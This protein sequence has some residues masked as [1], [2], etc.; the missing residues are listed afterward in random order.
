[1]RARSDRL[2][3]LELREWHTSLLIER[4]EVCPCRAGEHIVVYQRVSGAQR[5]RKSQFY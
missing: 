5:P 2:A 1:V 3:E 4:A